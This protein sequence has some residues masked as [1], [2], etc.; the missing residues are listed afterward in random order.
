MDL[1][2]WFFVRTVLGLFLASVLGAVGFFAGWML[3]SPSTSASLA[4]MFRVCGAGIGASIGGFVGWLRPEDTL[5]LKAATLGL[6]L[7]GGMAGAWGGLTY[8]SE[9]YE[10]GVFARGTQISTILGGAIVCNIVPGLFNMYWA[11]R[12]TRF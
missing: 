4:S 6:A 7:L 9:V 8:G 12:H 2:V 3:W 10:K 1:V 5:V 11:R